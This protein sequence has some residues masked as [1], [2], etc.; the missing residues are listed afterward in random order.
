MITP[1]QCKII[2]SRRK[3]Y[4]VEIKDGQI[5]LRLP[6]Y[7]TGRKAEDILQ[8]HSAWIMRKLSEQNR[9]KLQNPP[10]KV[11]S[12]EYFPVFDT[13]YVLKEGDKSEFNDAL[14]ITPGGNSAEKLRK[15]YRAMAKDI[16][17]DKLSEAAMVNGIYY[18]GMKVS[19][20]GTRWGSC[21][22]KKNIN[23]N[24][25][26]LLLPEYLAEHVIMHELAHIREMNHSRA[27]YAELAKLEPG[28]QTA[29]RQLRQYSLNIDNWE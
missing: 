2:F 25:R 28:W 12:G 16:L 15:L 13:L 18:S 8:K 21:S 29:E 9:K 4:A 14:Y 10:K 7:T 27:F 20:A 17:K 11:Q 19:N 22:W 3:S 26:L 1:E 5:I 23:L 24:W 6:L